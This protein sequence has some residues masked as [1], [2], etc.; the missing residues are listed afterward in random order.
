MNPSI[1]N[2]QDHCAEGTDTVKAPHKVPSPSLVPELKATAA[3][4][5]LALRTGN[6]IMYLAGLP[7]VEEPVPVRALEN[8]DQPQAQEQADKMPER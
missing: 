8:P 2:P 7:P 6:G 3:V 4:M 1:P 5:I